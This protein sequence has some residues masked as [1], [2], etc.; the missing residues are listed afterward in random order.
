[1]QA[2]YKELG[3]HFDLITAPHTDTD[4]EIAFLDTFFKEHSVRTVLDIACGSGRH[5]IALAK[6]GYEVTGVDYS[7]Y[8]LAVARSKI[9]D[10]AYVDFQNQSVAEMKFQTM[11]DAA[12]CMWSTFGE[13]PYRDMLERLRDCLPEGGYFVIDNA[14]WNNRIM[15]PQKVSEKTVE[16]EGVAIKVRIATTHEP[17]RVLRKIHYEMDGEVYD[18]DVTLF[19]FNEESFKELLGEFGF[20]HEK[21]YSDYR[22]ISDPNAGRYQYVFK[23]A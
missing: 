9:I 11:F 6:L 2:L 15:G 17:D 18:A 5:S 10:S 19:V 22:E 12:I 23:K 21:T 4:K 7:E 3:K 20:V 14:N 16:G 13:L 1:M 8:L